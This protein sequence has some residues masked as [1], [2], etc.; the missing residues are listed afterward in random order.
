LGVLVPFVK[1]WPVVVRA[2]RSGDSTTVE[3]SYSSAIAQT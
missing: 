3:L 1:G 2:S